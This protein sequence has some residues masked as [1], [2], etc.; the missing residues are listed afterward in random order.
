MTTQTRLQ[1]DSPDHTRQLGEAIGRAIAPGD[2][3]VLN[4]D[5]GAGKT[6]FTQGIA[7]GM[8]VDEPVTS[9]TFVVSRE[10]GEGRTGVRLTHVD[11]YRVWSLHEW[12]D[13][14]VDLES[15]GAVIEWGERI[16]EALPGDH[17]EVRLVGDGEVRTV[18][19]TSHGPRSQRLLAALGESR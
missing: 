12:D 15:G 6:T 13:L 2:V 18:I 3:V 11:A 9:P 5:L 4:G 1:S 10:M 17:L 14:D 16:S 19:V 8:G 7:R